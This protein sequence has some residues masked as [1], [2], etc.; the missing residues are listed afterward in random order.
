[1]SDADQSLLEKVR[2]SLAKPGQGA[3]SGVQGSV[4]T[5]SAGSYGARPDGDKT[6]PT[7]F[8]PRAAALFEATV[9]AAFLV[10]NADGEFD[11]T[12]R[13]AFEHV[14]VEACGGAVLGGQIAALVADLSD[15]L[16]E[17]GIDKRITMVARS[18][19]KSEQQRDVLRIAGLLAHVSGDVSDSERAVLGKL[20][21]SFGLDD[22]AVDQA[23][24]EVRVALQ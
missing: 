19:A 7:G 20:A 18:V 4:L 10:A 21:S 16:E 1:M 8:D 5:I 12:E 9:E 11:Q 23:L 2:R 3:P 17:D 13:T 15:Q 24:K 14:V 22:A 6:V